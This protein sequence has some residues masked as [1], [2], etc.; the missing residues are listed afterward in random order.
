MPGI[1]TK[2]IACFCTRIGKDQKG[3]T[4]IEYGLIA[5]LISTAAI[6]AWE[7]VGNSLDTVY[8]SLAGDVED[9]IPGGRG[10]TP[11][12]ANVNPVG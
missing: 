9:A 5:A 12:P 8:S 7:N 11:P 2:S 4:A 1:I 3:A 6:A 10:G